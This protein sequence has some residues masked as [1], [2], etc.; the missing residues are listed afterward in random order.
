MSKL[1]LST[2]RERRLLLYF[3][4][5]LQHFSLSFPSCLD[6]QALYLSSAV[7]PSVDGVGG[8]VEHLSLILEGRWFVVSR[9]WRPTSI[10]LNLDYGVLSCDLA[11]FGRKGKFLLAPNSQRMQDRCWMLPNS[12]ENKTSGLFE[13]K[14]PYKLMVTI[15]SLH[16]LHAYNMPGI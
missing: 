16:L 14:I 4:C 13:G 7:S 3:M 12:S 6:L 1:V 8:V 11:Q 10:Y 15:M 2:D 5:Q 9:I